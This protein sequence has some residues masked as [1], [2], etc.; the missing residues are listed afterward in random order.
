MQGISRWTCLK[1]SGGRGAR[2]GFHGPEP[3]LE[4]RALAQSALDVQLA[5]VGLHRAVDQ[6]EPQARPLSMGLGGEE[7]LQGML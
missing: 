2:I 7:G 6:G 1:G 3:H 4:Q 5:M